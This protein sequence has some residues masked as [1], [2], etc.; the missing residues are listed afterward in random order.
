LEKTH[1]FISQVDCT[2]HSHTVNQ[3]RLDNKKG[4]GHHLD[5]Q[6]AM[7]LKTRP[8][9]APTPQNIVIS[10]NFSKEILTEIRTRL[11]VA[12]GLPRL[13]RLR[14]KPRNPSTL[15]MKLVKFE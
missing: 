11:G 1:K 4:F 6:E 5:V 10:G 14:P 15:S 2:E 8:S 3:A 9:I 13:S 12:H 7:T